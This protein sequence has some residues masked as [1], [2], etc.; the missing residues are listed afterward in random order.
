M[1]CPSRLTQE[2]RLCV[3]TVASRGCGG[4]GSVGTRG[5]G[6]AGSPCE[7]EASC[8]RAALPG[9]VSSVSFRLRRQGWKNCGEMAGRA[10]GKTV[11]SWPSLLRSSPCE[12][13]SEPNRAD[14]IIQIRGAR[15]ARRNGRLPGDHGISRPAT[16]QG[17]PSDW[18][19]L[20]AAV[21]F[22]LRVLFAQRTAGASRHPA[23]PAPSWMRGWSDQAKL[24]RNAPR[25]RRSVSAS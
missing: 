10:Y 17:R 8:G 22:F 5:A 13:A 7:P 12:G 16:A 14:C 24:G 2:G 1:C 4:R 3:V 6:R 11:W 15:E 25:G 21:R 18:H 19:H 20:Y 23:F 9:F